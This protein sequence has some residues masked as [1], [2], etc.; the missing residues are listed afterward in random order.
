MGYQPPKESAMKTAN[1]IRTLRKQ[2]GYTQKQI[3]EKLFMT[4]VNYSAYERGQLIVNGA[5][6]RELAKIYNVSISFILDDEMNGCY[7][8]REQLETLIKAKSII[9]E[10]EKYIER[11]NEFKK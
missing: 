5:L 9:E 1:K 3:A 2:N 6:A 8:T 11:K 4:N 7:I 10:L